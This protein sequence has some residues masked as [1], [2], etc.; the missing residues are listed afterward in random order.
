MITGVSNTLSA[1]IPVTIWKVECG[2]TREMNCFGRLSR[3]SG[4]TRVPV[5]PHMMT[6]RIFTFSR[7]LAKNIDSPFQDLFYTQW[8]PA[9]VAHRTIIDACA[10]N[11][12]CFQGSVRNR[13]RLLTL[14]GARGAQTISIAYCHQVWDTVRIALPPLRA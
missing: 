2:P 7:S 4:Q 12:A 13:N 1:S 14:F 6:G 5:P 11:V 3:D 10:T 8:T 9:P